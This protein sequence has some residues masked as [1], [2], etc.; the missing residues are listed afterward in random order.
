MLL[1]SNE[2]VFRD[3]QW[4]TH[5]DDRVL[6]NNNVQVVSP[7]F[8]LDNSAENEGHDSLRF[9]V[10]LVVTVASLI[11]FKRSFIFTLT[12]WRTLK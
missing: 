6:P 8:S 5:S 11:N 1:K 7:F 3:Y 12:N 4:T 2:L 10:R 9:A